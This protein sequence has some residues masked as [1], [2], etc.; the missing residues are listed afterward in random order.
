MLME[1]YGQHEASKF[2]RPQRVLW[3]HIDKT[4]LHVKVRALIEGKRVV[5]M[6]V[7]RKGGEI[8]G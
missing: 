3:T 1:F 4:G 2:D 6:R 5:E 8:R 7:W